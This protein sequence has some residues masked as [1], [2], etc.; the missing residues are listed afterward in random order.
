MR[1]ELVLISWG[2]VGDALVCTPTIRALKQQDPERKIILY[3]MKKAHLD[4][5]RHNPHIDSLRLLHWTSMWRYPYHL[6]AYIFNKKLVNYTVF[7]FQHV[8]PPNL[9]SKSIKHI[10]GDIFNLELDDIT[11]EITL[12]DQ[13]EEAA[14]QRL[15]PYKNVVIMHIHSRIAP[16]HLWD[17]NNWNEL[18]RSFPDYTFIQLGFPDEAK[19]EGAIDWRGKTQL[20]EAFALIKNA[21]SFLGVDGGLSH[22]TN[23]FGTPGVVLF[24]RL[25]PGLLGA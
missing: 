16:N 3:C 22:A 12:T 5:Y 15:A 11:N 9:Y 2:G 18:V 19:V 25:Q 7:L 20:R 24:W 21:S 13:E 23:A 6:F 8:D 1:N 10:V 14:K 17:I 4:V